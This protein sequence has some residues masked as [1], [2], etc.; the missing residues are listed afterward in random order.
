LGRSTGSRT[1]TGEGTRALTVGSPRSVSSP[2]SRPFRRPPVVRR[3]PK[4]FLLGPPFLPHSC[5]VPRPSICPH[6]WGFKASTPPSLPFALPQDLVFHFPLPHVA[7]TA[8]VFVPLGGP[9][10][11]HGQGKTRRGKMIGLL[12]GVLLWVV[13]P[14]GFFWCGGEM[15]KRLSRPRWAWFMSWNRYRCFLL[16]MRYLERGQD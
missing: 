5:A 16:K 10:D 13:L 15:L 7:L 14:L 3:P 11:F 2:I 4:R 8:R 6:T 9:A 1:L 12:F